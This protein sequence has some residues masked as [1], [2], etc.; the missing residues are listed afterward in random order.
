M[1]LQPVTVQTTEC[2]EWSGQKQQVSSDQV[3]TRPLVKQGYRI[4]WAMIPRVGVERVQSTGQIN[5]K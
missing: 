5:V 3:V 4:D 2:L 1:N